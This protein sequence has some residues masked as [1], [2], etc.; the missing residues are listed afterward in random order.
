MNYEFLH[1]IAKE[2]I[3]SLILFYSMLTV[4]LER[5]KKELLLAAN[6][7]SRRE[8]SILLILSFILY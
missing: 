4:T 7:L 3:N 6:F 5:N 2:L 8:I 1:N